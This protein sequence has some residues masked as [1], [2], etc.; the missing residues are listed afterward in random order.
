MN[1][2]MHPK[3]PNNTAIKQR[4]LRRLIWNSDASGTY[5]RAEH[6]EIGTRAHEQNTAIN[7]H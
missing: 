3:R 4:D 5:K 2:Q 7:N 6:G 1:H